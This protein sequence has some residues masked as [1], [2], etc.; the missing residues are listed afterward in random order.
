MESEELFKGT[1]QRPK[2][3]INNSTLLLTSE[4]PK[5]EMGMRYKLK[6]QEEIGKI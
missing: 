5:S 6:K 2:I 3:L 1:H 4:K